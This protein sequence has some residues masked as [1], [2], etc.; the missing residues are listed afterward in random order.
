MSKELD[1]LSAAATQGEWRVTGVMCGYKADIF[2]ATAQRIP[3]CHHVARFFAPK[4]EKA[5][6]CDLQVRQMT[7]DAAVVIEANS[8]FV[9]ALVNAYRTGQLVPRDA[10]GARSGLSIGDRVEKIKGSCWTG[11]VVGFYR[12]DLT[13]YGVC[14][15]SEREPGSVQIYPEAALKILWADEEPLAAAL[16]SIKEAGDHAD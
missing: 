4:P 13:P 10:V 5:P 3:D 2:V 14:V 7:N 11:R 1:A 9:A 16:A 8:K 15:E 12:T 6:A